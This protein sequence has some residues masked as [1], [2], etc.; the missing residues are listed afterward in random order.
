MGMSIEQIINQVGLQTIATRMG[1]T[2]QRVNNWRTRGFPA[3]V[4]ISFC[5]AT[6]WRALP[7][8]IRPDIYPNK[9]D[10][11]PVIPRVAA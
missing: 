11:Y 2:A 3:E 4:V 7:H 1:T 9:Y 5:R 8:D 10:G 6:E